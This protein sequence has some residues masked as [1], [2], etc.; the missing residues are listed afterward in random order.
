MNFPLLLSGFIQNRQ[1]S[2]YNKKIQ[3]RNVMEVRLVGDAMFRADGRLDKANNRL[4]DG[5]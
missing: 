5:L 2:H 4:G 1:L 3:M